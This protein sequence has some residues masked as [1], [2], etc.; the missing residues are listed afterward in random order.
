M[1]MRMMKG[2]LEKNNKMKTRVQLEKFIQ[3]W[4]LSDKHLITLDV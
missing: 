3:L 1:M 2:S 4:K